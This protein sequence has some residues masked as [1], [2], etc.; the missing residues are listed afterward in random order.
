M[1]NRNINYDK[2]F[3]TIARHEKMGRDDYKYSYMILK[4]NSARHFHAIMRELERQKF[5]IINCF[6]IHD[7]ET[8]NMALHPDSKVSKYLIPISRMYH[9]FYGNYAI[10]VMIGKQKIYYEDFVTQ[11]CRLKMA[12]RA[13]FKVDYVAYAFDTS[14]MGRENE[15]QMLKIIGKNGEEVKKDSMN[16]PG[17]YMVFLTNE[18]HSPDANV[19][20]TVDELALLRNIGVIS[21]ENIIPKGLIQSMM[22]YETYAY[23]KDM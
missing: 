3:Q 19:Q 12:I 13:R 7:Y 10:M 15:E 4:P 9:D 16:E 20:E 21:D 6:A 14:K 5:E 18:I 22:R 17:T 8:V 11:V 2:L 23:L 1:E